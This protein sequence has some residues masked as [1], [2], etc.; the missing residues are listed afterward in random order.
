MG[1]RK[2]FAIVS[3]PD[4]GKTTLTEQLLLMGGAIHLAGTVKS[5]KS[6]RF[7]TSD[8]MEMEK[9]RGISI[10]TSVMQFD[11]NDFTINLLDTPGHA[12]FSEDTY[13]TLTAV[14]SALVVIDSAKG[15]ESRTIKL[16]EVCKM[17]KIPIITFINKVDRESKNILELLDE[18]ENVLGVKCSVM[19]LPYGS[20]NSFKGIY[21][22]NT[23]NFHCFNKKE[24]TTIIHG[25]DSIK[26]KFPESYSTF[27]E[28]LELIR[29]T[30]HQFDHNEYLQGSITPVFFGSAFYCFGVDVLLDAFVNLSP[31]PQAR[32]TQTRLVKPKE[33]KFSGFVFKIQANMDPN[34]HDR[35]AF[36][37]IVS[38]DF[39]KGMRITNTR[40]GK[41]SC[42]HNAMTFLA[43]D[44]ENLQDATSGDVIGIPNHGT[45][46]LGDAF[47][48]GEELKFI[49]IPNFAPEIF[50]EVILKNPLK[51]K[52]LLK[53]LH[54]LS[55]EGAVQVFKPIASNSIILGAI[56]VLQFEVVQERLI[57]E[58]SV[59]CNFITSNIITARWVFT[60]EETI[61]NKFKN[62]YIDNLAYDSSENLTFLAP[63]MA[64]L[65]IAQESSQGISFQ[66]TV[67]HQ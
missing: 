32:M 28:E 15:V 30:T 20:G 46:K 12:D 5:A 16:M 4:A 51:S 61:L 13:R 11:Y 24:K 65:R 50:R 58:Y 41:N 54:Q 35:V 64:K 25:L 36:M 14:D 48:T 59:E 7:A 39:Y 49:G 10:S 27:D 57:N 19:N 26:N 47:T 62:K 3:H 38:G 43:G 31:L 23:D 33:S 60:Q 29:G 2:T 21:D 67:E 22:F 37:R 63:S 40:T 44:R 52:A 6:K 55:E 18:I 1:V 8:W 56:G 53:G 17:R 34:H 45:I 66:S 9:K 42:I